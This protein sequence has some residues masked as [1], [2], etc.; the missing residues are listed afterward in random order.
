MLIC[1]QG[2]HNL[3][4]VLTSI[5]N[6]CAIKYDIL[7]KFETLSED[8]QAIVDYVQAKHNNESINF[9]TQEPQVD[10][11]KCRKE[12]EKIPIDVRN[13]LYQIFK[14]DYLSFGYQYNELEYLFC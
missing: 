10:S 11:K 5:C 7:A 1:S 9:P 6:P 2:V 14:E 4:E 13:S 12:F 3:G 8:S